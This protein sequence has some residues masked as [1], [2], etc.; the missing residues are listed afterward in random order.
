MAAKHHGIQVIHSR[1]CATYRGGKYCSCSP[2]Y[3]AEIWI[4]GGNRKMRRSFSTLAAARNWRHD[5]MSALRK[6]TMAAGGPI[7]IRDAAEVLIKG[8]RSGA[9]RT[10]SG[11]EYKPSAIRNLEQALK[12][13]ILPRLGHDGRGGHARRRAALRRLP[14]HHGS[15]PEHD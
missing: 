11:D 4:P 3:K 5:A 10:R 8:I 13:R 7:T 1:K 15:Q 12:L 9:V 14:P 6:G 2:A